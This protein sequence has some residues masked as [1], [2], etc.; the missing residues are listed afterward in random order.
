M[1]A[2]QEETNWKLDTWAGERLHVGSG[3]VEEVPQTRARAA[4]HDVAL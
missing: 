1:G 2:V 4:N 3:S